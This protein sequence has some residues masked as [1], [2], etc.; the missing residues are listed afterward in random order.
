MT[1]ATHHEAGFISLCGWRSLFCI[2][3]IER[4]Q[5][6]K[7]GEGGWGA[8][9]RGRAYPRF[10][11]R[12]LTHAALCP[13][14]YQLLTACPSE[15]DSL[16]L[17]RDD[18]TVAV[19]SRVRPQRNMVQSDAQLLVL[20][21]HECLWP[22]RLICTPG[23]LRLIVKVCACAVLSIE[24][25]TTRCHAVAAYPSYSSRCWCTVVDRPPCCRS[26]RTALRSFVEKSAVRLTGAAFWQCVWATW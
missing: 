5:R 14:C 16:P 6:L 24:V 21:K 13:R 22:L 10:P 12:L 7:G 11:A 4:G 9:F 8:W 23:L 18:L 3:E 19:S 2:D 17:T 25:H 1:K 15:S 26:P 20:V